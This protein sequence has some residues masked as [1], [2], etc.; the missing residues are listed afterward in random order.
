MRGLFGRGALHP[1]TGVLLLMA[2]GAQ[3]ADLASSSAPDLTVC[4]D[5]SSAS[6]ARDQ[7][8]AEAVAKRGGLKLR[9]EKFD[10]EAGD[11]GVSVK[12]F[13][14][15]L[16]KTCQ[17]VLGYPV[18]AASPSVPEG[19]L[20]TKPYAQTG[21]ALV[22]A[23]G[24]KAADLAGLPPG[25]EVA[26]TYETAPNLYF[27]DHPNISSDVHN[28]DSDTLEAV[29][30]GTDKAAMVWQ[31]TVEAY[32]AAHPTAPKLGM[33]PL[34]EPHARYNVVALYLPAQVHQAA[35]F[36]AAAAALTTPAELA[37]SAPPALYTVAQAATGHSKYLGNCAMCHGA[38]LMGRSGPSLKGPHFASAKSAYTV[39]DVFNIVAQNMPAM[40]PGSLQKDDYV[41][42]M[43]YLLQQNGYPA[44]TTALDFEGAS[45]SKVPL[46]YHGG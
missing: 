13:R 39:S 23:P 20:V 42:V 45:A 12:R 9:I 15:L 10:G 46:V 22:V 11:D 14:S 2:G 19:F 34:A 44:G 16:T 5:S 4:V 31:P 27:A 8:E 40:N 33:Y 17:L 32:I 6:A 29:V 28:T 24:S 35:T 7:A 37:V 1:A 21:F 18:D 25:T 3:A 26:V 43:A 41:Q 36:E 30:K 38:T